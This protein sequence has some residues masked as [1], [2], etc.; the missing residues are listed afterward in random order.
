MCSFAF[1]ANSLDPIGE[2]TDFHV[3]AQLRWVGRVR[4]LRGS[5]P[6]G[7]GNLYGTTYEGGNVGYGTVFKL[8]TSGTE[9]VLY[10]FADTT[11]DGGYPYARLVRDTD[12]N[13]YGTTVS[14][15]SSHYERCSS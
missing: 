2:S 12:G 6:D 9:T 1:V 4:S 7:T 13:I 5:A 14:G 3:A 11:T 8:D 15:G 10:S